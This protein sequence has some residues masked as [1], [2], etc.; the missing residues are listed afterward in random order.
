MDFPA[1]LHFPLN[2]ETN[3]MLI[4]NLLTGCNALE[5]LDTVAQR[6][7]SF[8]LMRYAG[9]RLSGTAKCPQHRAIASK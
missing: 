4:V 8:L 3:P 6:A 7:H 2:L 1:P 5:T 9:A